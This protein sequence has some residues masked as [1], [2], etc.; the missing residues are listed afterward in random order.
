MPGTSVRTIR[1]ASSAPS[2][3]AMAAMPPATATVVQNACQ[4]SG[5][6]EDEGVGEPG[7]SLGR[8]IE[9]RRRQEALV[10]DQRQRRRHG[11]R[12]DAEDEARGTG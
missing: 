9:E 5:S 4:K 6:V 10:D 3:T 7:S 11:Q 12:G 2:G 8:G 1:K